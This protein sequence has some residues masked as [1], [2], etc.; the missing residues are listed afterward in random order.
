[1][2]AS[3]PVRS[4]AGAPSGAAGPTEAHS[5]ALSAA[6][7]PAPSRRTAQHQ[8]PGAPAVITGP[9]T[10][11]WPNVQAPSSRRPVGTPSAS[12]RNS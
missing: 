11:R 5:S 10:A 8:Q 1:M 4:G 7:E 9:T 3:G 12:S 2:P 6:S